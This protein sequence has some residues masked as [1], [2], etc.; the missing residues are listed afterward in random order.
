VRGPVGLRH[1]G[2]DL[3][4]ATQRFERGQRELRGA[5]EEELQLLQRERAVGAGVFGESILADTTLDLVARDGV[6]PVDEQDALE[7]IHLVLEDA[8]A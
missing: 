3:V 5:V 6:Q 2:D 7:V 1:H 4:R 8:G